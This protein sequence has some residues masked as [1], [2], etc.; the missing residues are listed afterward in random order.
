[1]SAQHFI[2]GA[3]WCSH[4]TDISTGDAYE[5]VRE[6]D[7]Q[8][9]RATYVDCTA[10]DLSGDNKTVCDWVKDSTNGLV[11][12][13]SFVEKNANGEMAFV[14]KEAGKHLHKATRDAI[15]ALPHNQ[16]ALGNLKNTLGCT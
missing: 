6:A 10:T 2:V 7:D 16:A 1:M 13:P 12:Y 5:S 11:G 15:C 14:E 4:S 8:T 3:S 9:P